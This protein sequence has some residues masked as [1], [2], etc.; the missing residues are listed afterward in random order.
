MN[1]LEALRDRKSVNG[2]RTPRIPLEDFVT[3]YT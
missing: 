3:F 1:T 2:Y